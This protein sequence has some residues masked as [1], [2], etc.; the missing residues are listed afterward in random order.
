MSQFFVKKGVITS[1]VGKTVK[2]S[3]R[4]KTTE[5]SKVQPDS[6]QQKPQ[7]PEID[8]EVL[9]AKRVYDFSQRLRTDEER[10]EEHLAQGRKKSPSDD[11]PVVLNDELSDIYH[12][13]GRMMA[14]L[15]GYSGGGL[16]VHNQGITDFI[17]PERRV[18]FGQ[19]LGE[20][21]QPIKLQ[22]GNK[23]EKKLNEKEKNTL[24]AV[25][26]WRKNYG[27]T[28]KAEGF[29]G[30]YSEESEGSKDSEE[31]AIQ[32]LGKG[33]HENF[34]KKVSF[35]PSSDIS[36]SLNTNGQQAGYKIVD[37]TKAQPSIH[38]SIKDVIST[39]LSS[40]AMIGKSLAATQC[41][42]RV[43][44][45]RLRESHA[46]VT[47]T[48]NA[49][50]L[51]ATS[52]FKDLTAK[53]N[54]LVRCQ[55]DLTT[56][57]KKS[58]ELG[59]IKSALLKVE[60]LSDKPESLSM[61][62]KEFTQLL[63]I[64][65]LL[66]QKFNLKLLL[67][68]KITKIFSLSYRGEKN[69]LGGWAMDGIVDIVEILEILHKVKPQDLMISD[70]R[71]VDELQERDSFKYDIEYFVTRSIIPGLTNFASN[72]WDHEDPHDLV[73]VFLNL[74]RTFPEQ[75]FY[76]F[77]DS[78]IAKTLIKKIEAWNMNE[79]L[80]YPHLW[81]QPWLPILTR[82][83]GNRIDAVFEKL[84]GKFRGI[85][86][87]WSPEDKYAAKLLLPWKDLLSKSLWEDILYLDI[88]PKVIFNLESFDA[89][90]RRMNI[91]PLTFFIEWSEFVPAELTD[92]L[93]RE[94]ISPKIEAV[95]AGWQDAVRAEVEEWTEGWL[96]LFS[97][98]S[99][100]LQDTVK[101]ALMALIIKY[102]PQSR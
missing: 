60:S 70:V 33:P 73:E 64:A 46:V 3:Y 20:D 100:D 4:P 91:E 41:N 101:E 82:D 29:D 57:I 102:C 37:M 12:K 48:F 49:Q 89:D 67:L 2:V 94:Y 68:K 69:I 40:Q 38:E 10:L 24:E 6:H 8:K 15:G 44:L 76:D 43:L 90:P 81:I 18:K 63:D 30:E 79:S 83:P 61:V 96:V 11:P 98:G 95:L 86:V 32:L 23:A 21:G 55:H 26:K 66:W 31:V 50:K 42:G 28:I 58:T 1:E 78:V 75:I 51:R 80:L 16:G 53:E 17:K 71:G 72:E 87:A 36:L 13:A 88:L 34:K 54:D 62:I 14:K 5:A 19:K 59:A 56:M 22:K 47:A 99:S 84:K 27:S 35:K 45:E 97:G 65:D 39:K 85:L 77:F 9:L 74:E 25:H 92:D 52:A 7:E 93:I